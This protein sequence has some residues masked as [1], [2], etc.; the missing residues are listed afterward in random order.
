MIGSESL[1]SIKGVDPHTGMVPKLIADIREVIDKVPGASEQLLDYVMHCI[2]HV[3]RHEK[4]RT[5]DWQRT[6]GQTRRSASLDASQSTA[7]SFRRKRSSTPIREETE[8]DNEPQKKLR[9][10][11]LDISLIMILTCRQDTPSAPFN[12]ECREIYT[13]VIADA[14]NAGFIRA[15]YQKYRKIITIERL[16]KDETD[17]VWGYFPLTLI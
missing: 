6:Y 4:V 15:D 11:S 1:D 9:A 16:L 8:D 5:I 17:K 7:S 3:E 13:R 14:D 12:F 10:L 2:I